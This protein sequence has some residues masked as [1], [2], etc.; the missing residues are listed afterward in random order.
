[1]THLLPTLLCLPSILL[2]PAH[3]LRSVDSL[4]QPLYKANMRL[5]GAQ[6]EEL[7]AVHKAANR[8]AAFVLHIR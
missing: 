2:L 5:Q 6:G 3:Q 4:F 1:M 8:H 7:Q